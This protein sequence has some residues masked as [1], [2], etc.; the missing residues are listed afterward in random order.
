LRY[1]YEET[2]GLFFFTDVRQTDLILRKKDLYDNATP[3]GNSTMILNFQRLGLLLDRPEWLDKSTKMLDAVRETV[4]RY[5]LS[6]ERWATALQYEKWPLD[7]IAVI[8]ENAIEKALTLQQRFWPNKVVAAS[9]TPADDLALLAGKTGEPDALIY[10]CRNF[11]C[12][13]PVTEL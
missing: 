1:F 7:E 2:T 6:F 12:Q 4:E 11:A 10:I 3:S 5:P 13:R 9:R 8:G